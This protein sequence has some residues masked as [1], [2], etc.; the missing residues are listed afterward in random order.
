MSAVPSPDYKVKTID[1]KDG[2][3]CLNVSAEKNFENDVRE[4]VRVILRNHD[5]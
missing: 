2:C 1:L 5:N 3:F 4:K